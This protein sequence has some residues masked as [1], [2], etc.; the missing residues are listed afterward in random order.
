MRLAAERKLAVRGWKILKLIRSLEDFPPG[1]RGGALT[2]GNFDGVHRGHRQIIGRLRAAAQRVGG[3]AVVFTFD[4]HPALLLRPREAPPPL[5]W[6]DRKAELLAELGVDAVLAC[7]TTEALLQL[8]WVDFF[9][10]IIRGVLGAGA[11]V[12]GSNFRFGRDRAGDTGLLG[13]RCRAAGMEFEVV[14]VVEEDAATVSSSRIRS[15]IRT[16]AVGEAR[17]LLT[18]PYRIRGLVVHG[19]ARGAKLGFPTANLDGIDTLVPAAGVYAGLARLGS[20]V[21]G[22][23]VHVGPNPTFGEGALKVEAHLLDF[24]GSLYGQLLELDFLERLRGVMP[25]ANAAALQEQL[26]ADVAAA[27]GLW[28]LQDAGTGR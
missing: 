15:L 3:P 18:Q 8:E 13:E 4:P 20:G 25:F 24:S 16:G 17:R 26:H 2:I 27:R 14:P 11:V 7:P 10:N 21:W 1:L 9:E 5:T 22:A 23:A 6:I 28:R 19:A 12:E